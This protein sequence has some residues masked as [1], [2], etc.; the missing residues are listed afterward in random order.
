MNRTTAVAQSAVQKNS[1]LCFF[2]RLD[3]C[4][5]AVAIAVSFQKELGPDD[6]LGIDDEGSR[7]G[8]SVNSGANRFF[9]QN[10][11]GF[12]RLAAGVGEQGI[13]DV[14]LSGELHQGF[15]RIVAD[16]YY[17]TTGGF[18]FLH[19]LL[20]LNQLLFAE[21]SPIGRPIKHQDNRSL[22]EEGT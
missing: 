20:Q 19:T 22:F 10:F 8:D 2:Y 14:T 21:R 17:S 6:A 12:N 9:V 4:F 18:N 1:L 5:N 15:H 7:V 13:G 3:Q 11:V 16:P